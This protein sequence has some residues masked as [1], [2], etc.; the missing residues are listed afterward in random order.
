M[1]G[2]GWLRLHSTQP[3]TELPAPPALPAEPAPPAADSAATAPDSWH[4][5]ATAAAATTAAT[6][7]TSAAFD[8]GF[9]RLVLAMRVRVLKQ[10]MRLPSRFVFLS[11]SPTQQPLADALKAKLK[12]R[13]GI[14]A[15]RSSDLF[16]C[17]DPPSLHL[18]HAARKAYAAHASSH[19]ASHSARTPTALRALRSPPARGYR[20]AAL[21]VL[22]Q[23]RC[24]RVPV[25]RFAARRLAAHEPGDSQGMGRGAS[26]RGGDSGGGG[27]WRD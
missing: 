13:L 12:E 15:L 25:R 5:V 20:R 9:D 6:A 16:L 19:H 17:G 14:H 7:A 8:Y 27:R 1:P 10:P 3:A 4:D 26:S 24:P 18:K 2:R 11:C 21:R 22:L 23:V